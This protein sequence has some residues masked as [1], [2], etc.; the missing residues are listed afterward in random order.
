[1]TTIPTI[2]HQEGRAYVINRKQANDSG[3]MGLLRLLLIHLVILFDTR[4]THSFI[5]SKVAS[6]KGLESHKHP[7]DLYV[8]LATAI[9]EKCSVMYKKR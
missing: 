9:M 2:G 7:I 1:M 8:S 3:T 5:S 6:Q 4:A